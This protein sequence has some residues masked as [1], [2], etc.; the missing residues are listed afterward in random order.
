MSLQLRE[1]TEEGVQKGR[2][3]RTQKSSVLQTQLGGATIGSQKGKDQR[4]GQHRCLSVQCV[5]FDICAQICFIYPF[6]MEHWS[7]STLYWMHMQCN[8]MCE[9]NT[10]CLY[11]KM[12]E[13]QYGK[14]AELQPFIFA[15]PTQAIVSSSFCCSTVIMNCGTTKP[16]A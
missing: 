13:M 12:K 14:H 7:E 5:C 11:I 1:T 2:R 4:L 6:M 15:H 16:L 10:V 3:S 9:Q 8:C